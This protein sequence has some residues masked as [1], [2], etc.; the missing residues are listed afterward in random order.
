MTN[1]SNPKEELDRMSRDAGAGNYEGPGLL[2]I[3]PDDPTTRALAIIGGAASVTRPGRDDGPDHDALV[4]SGILRILGL[5]GR[6][7]ATIGSIPRETRIPEGAV[8]VFHPDCPSDGPLREATEA[9]VARATAD[10]VRVPTLHLFGSRADYDA[11]VCAG[12]LSAEVPMSGDF[13]LV[14]NDANG[15]TRALIRDIARLSEIG[16]DRAIIDNAILCLSLS[17]FTDGV[18]SPVIEI[19]GTLREHTERKIAELD[20]EMTHVIRRHLGATPEEGPCP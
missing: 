12:T 2:V 6:V 3:C 20:L 15:Q 19:H 17:L 16:G 4:R 14:D 10:P 5:G 11:A 18:P 8:C 7:T 1:T 9:W 13:D